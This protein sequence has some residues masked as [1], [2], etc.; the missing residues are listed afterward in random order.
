MAVQ[1]SL[2]L[3]LDARE[4]DLNSSYNISFVAYKQSNGSGRAEWESVVEVI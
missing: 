1:Y 4:H 2:S 3:S